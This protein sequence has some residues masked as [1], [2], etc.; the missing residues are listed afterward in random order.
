MIIN[1]ISIEY[2]VN[3]LYGSNDDGCPILKMYSYMSA[4]EGLYI[5]G[6]DF[7]STLG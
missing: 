1:S 6:G 7:N 5:I 3:I 2:I 4:Q